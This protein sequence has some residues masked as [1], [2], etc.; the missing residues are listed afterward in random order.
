MKNRKQKLNNNI[1]HSIFLI[2]F[3]NNFKKKVVKKASF[4]Y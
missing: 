2:N 4:M 1:L 3:K